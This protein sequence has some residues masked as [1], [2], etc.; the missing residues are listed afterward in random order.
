MIS[1]DSIRADLAAQLSEQMRQHGFAWRKS[2]SEFVRKNSEINHL[3]RIKVLPWTGWCGVE[4]VVF[5]GSPEVIRIFND[6]LGRKLLPNG[7]TVGFGISNRIKGRGSYKVEVA[8]DVASVAQAV[9]EDF[10]EVAL[11]FFAQV[12]NLAAIDSLMNAADKSG[13][14]KPESVD[15]ACM[16]LIAAKLCN[17]PA[18][19]QIVEAY[20]AFCRDAQGVALAQ[21]ILKV[22]D[23][24]KE[25]G[26]RPVLTLDAAG[27]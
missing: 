6:A 23:Y 20:F 26:T 18:F 8:D 2:G 15:R 5:V 25:G 7:P 12:H 3:F 27:D 14:Y 16:G 19:P 10:E 24:L 9:R 21:P 1:I 11:P 22:R 4:P 13:Y 17:N